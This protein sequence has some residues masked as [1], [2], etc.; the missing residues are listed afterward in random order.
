MDY[1]DQ[2]EEY[3]NDDD[4]IIIDSDSD[5]GFDIPDEVFIDNDFEFVPLKDKDEVYE[6]ERIDGWT[7]DDDWE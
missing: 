4:V 5:S 3:Y 6:Y 7:S 2:Y 1:E